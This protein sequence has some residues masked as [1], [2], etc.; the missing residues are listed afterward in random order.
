M[1]PLTSQQNLFE[2]S[3]RIDYEA[4]ARQAYRAGRAVTLYHGTHSGNAERLL[5]HGKKGV[6]SVGA[7]QGQ[8]HL[9]YV[10]THPENARWFAEQSGGQDILQISV[11]ARQLCVDPEDGVHETV[12]A[13]LEAA[14]RTGLPVNLAIKGSLDASHF[15][16][17]GPAPVLVQTPLQK[18]L[19]DRFGK[20]TA[21][22]GTLQKDN[23]MAWF[24]Q[25]QCVDEEGLPQV[26]YHGTSVWDLGERKLGDIDAF[27]RMASVTQVRRKPSLDTVGSWFSSNPTEGGA[28]MYSGP[29]G[30]IYPVF[31][32][33]LDP[34]KTSFEGMT[35]RAR[36][37]GGQK[38]DE[39]VNQTSVDALRYWLKETGRD[40]ICLRHNPGSRSTEFKH[41]TGWIALEPTQVKSALGNCG[42]F[43]PKDPS[44]SDALARAAGIEL[45][46]A[47]T[48][49]LQALDAIAETA[50]LPRLR[51]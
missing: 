44:M 2:V 34:W 10:T 43:D 15:Q 38:E 16:R 23:F 46:L 28:A 45:A 4:R 26:M 31:L 51:P 14:V 48:R 13:E 25:S 20:A 12:L 39:M 41:Q 49:R 17:F 6:A 30:A 33:I 8:P 21:P 35:R 5:D 29:Q 24:G 3:N 11:P 27:D 42:A 36:A 7:N 32:Q 50:T 9:L 1:T 19:A 40:G 47:T 18:Y 22:D 37:L